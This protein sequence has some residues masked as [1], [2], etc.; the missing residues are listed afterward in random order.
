MP[1][2][3]KGISFF[4]NKVKYHGITAKNIIKTVNKFLNK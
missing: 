2:N 4:E 3:Y 1:K